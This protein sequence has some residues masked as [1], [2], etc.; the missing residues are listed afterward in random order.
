MSDCEIQNFCVKT[1]FIG[2]RKINFGRI[3]CG[4]I[5]IVKDVQSADKRE[6]EGNAQKILENEDA[7]FPHEMFIRAMCT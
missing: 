3:T 6:Q 5:N 4:D 2:K 7:L 1:A